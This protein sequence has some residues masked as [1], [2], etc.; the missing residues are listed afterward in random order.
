MAIYWKAPVHSHLELM[1][2]LVMHG[3][4]TRDMRPSCG[5]GLGSTQKVVGYL[6]NHHTTIAA[7]GT[8]CWACQWAHRSSTESEHHSP[9]G[10]TEPRTHEFS[11]LATEPQESTCLLSQCYSCRPPRECWESRSS[12]LPTKPFPQSLFSLK[13]V[14]HHFPFN[15]MLRFRFFG[16]QAFKL[17]LTLRNHKFGIVLKINFPFP[18]AWRKTLRLLSCVGLRDFPAKQGRSKAWC[19]G[20]L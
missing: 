7:V 2:S 10:L 18:Q 5:A 17:R 8:T 14:A 1:I 19:W 11:W 9:E 20:L 4:L 12:R 3:L 6:H 13:G 15:W 16:L